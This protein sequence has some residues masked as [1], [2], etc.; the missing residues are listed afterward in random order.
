M[1]EERTVEE[2]KAA[3][4]PTE[5]EESVETAM[6]EATLGQMVEDWD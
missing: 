3:A 4:A 2:E 6:V 5:T 1:V